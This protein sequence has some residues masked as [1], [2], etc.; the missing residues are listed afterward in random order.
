MKFI[1]YQVI[2][3]VTDDA[4][5]MLDREMMDKQV[6]AGVRAALRLDDSVDIKVKLDYIEDPKQRA[7]LKARQASPISEIDRG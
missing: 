5:R 7:D 3:P 1:H 2:I 4:V 6:T